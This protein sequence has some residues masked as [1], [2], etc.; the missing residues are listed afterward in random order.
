M[1]D[2]VGQRVVPFSGVGASL[3]LV[4]RYVR[5]TEGAILLGGITCHSVTVEVGKAASKRSA[6]YYA[7]AAANRWKRSPGIG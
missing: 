6:P 5:Q 3:E 1:A 4:A 7:T 2:E